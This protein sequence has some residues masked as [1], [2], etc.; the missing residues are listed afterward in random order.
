MRITA[1]SI[2]ILLYVVLGADAFKVYRGGNS[3]GPLNKIRDND[4]SVEGDKV[5]PSNKCV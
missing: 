3:S 1:A 2:L 5:M 4:F